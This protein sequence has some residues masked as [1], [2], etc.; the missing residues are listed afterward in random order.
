MIQPDQKDAFLRYLVDNIKAGELHPLTRLSDIE[1]F[2][3]SE[4]LAMLT[5]FHELRLIHIDNLNS[6]SR[7][8]R[9]IMRVDAHDFILEGG[10]FGRYELFQKN[11][12]K[13]LHEVER[14]EKI[15]GSQQSEVINIKKNI[16]EYVGLISNITTISTFI[17]DAVTNSN[18]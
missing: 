1:G 16:S 17:K 7:F 3:K 5:Q 12:I 10:F 8:Y 6:S 13:L 4:V 14:L 11:V 9:I 2:N 18:P 15:E